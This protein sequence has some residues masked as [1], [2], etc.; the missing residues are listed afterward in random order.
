[1]KKFLIVVQFDGRRYFGFQANQNKNTI[2]SQIEL[3]I[4]KLFKQPAKINGCS[5]T[6]A[7]VSA[8]QFLFTFCMDTKLPADRVAYKLNRFLPRDIQCQKSQLVS[9]DFDLRKHVVQKTYQ[10]A[11]YFGEHIQ[12][13]FEPF[14]VYVGNK[15]NFQNMQ[16]C[17]NLLTGKHNYKSF[18]NI[19][20]EVVNY[21]RQISS[22]TFTQQKN[23]VLIEISA[24]SFL[25]N[26]VRVIVG[27]LVECAKGTLSADD[28]KN[29]FALQDRSKNIA[30]TMSSKGL[31][32]KS[33]TLN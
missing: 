13:L 23:L 14:A 31:V 30:K 32:L 25:Y 11:I 28:I 24:K 10:Y 18:C 2:Q 16:T 21:N 22:I 29:L 19:S 5:R 6:D 15:F 20:P 27:T 26:M 17:A 9:M 4:E 8:R 12:P 33:V 1:M 7:G 3:A